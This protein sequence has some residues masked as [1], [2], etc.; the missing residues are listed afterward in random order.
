MTRI[1]LSGCAG[2]MGKVIA[3]MV[4]DMPEASIVAGLDISPCTCAFPVYTVPSD[5]KEEA[6]VV[7]DFSHPAAFDNL[8]NFASSRKMPLVMCTTGLSSV[9]V[10]RLKELA[11]TL[12]VFFSANMSLGVNL[13]IELVKKAAVLIGEEFD[14][15]IIEK[16]HNQKIDA[17]SGTALAIADAI[18]EVMPYEIE[19]VYD[20]H[21]ARKKRSSKELGIHA[22]RGGSIVGEH[23][24][25]FAGDNEIIEITHSAT[26]KNIFARGA[27]RAALF[28]KDK[29]EGLYDMQDL[30]SQESEAE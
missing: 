27:L 25:L 22:V 19:Y 26:S 3:D 10:F 17:P 14:M 8:I 4:Q 11:K 24:V 30:V 21:S 1:I 29:P 15:E 5:C 23:T 9:Q 20:R 2:K 16:H 28:L 18:S 13:M 12:P 7:I 6:D